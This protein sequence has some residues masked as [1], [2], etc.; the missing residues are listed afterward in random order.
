M[1]IIKEQHVTKCYKGPC[2]MTAHIR[3]G[4]L[5]L[6][7]ISDIHYLIS[8]VFSWALRKSSYKEVLSHRNY[9]KT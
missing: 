4:A 2:N 5:A 8:S 1:L 7:F 3:C 6:R 9:R